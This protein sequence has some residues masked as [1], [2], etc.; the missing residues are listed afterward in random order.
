MAGFGG[1]SSSGGGM[2]KKQKKG[3]DQVLKLKPKSQWDKY[4]ILKKESRV[5]VA[6]RSVKSDGTAGEWFDVGQIKS[7]GNEFTELAVVVQRGMI[8]EHA[9]R[10]FP[11]Q[12]LPKDQVEWAYADSD[13]DGDNYTWVAVD[14][15]VTSGA[16]AG[17]EK[18]IGFEGNPD[19][20]GYYSRVVKQ[21]AGDTASVTLA[22]GSNAPDRSV[23]PRVK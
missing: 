20:T 10:L 11:L 17:I 5:K 14:K 4:K 23:L 19:A 7:E 6:A 8:V 12:F 2:K 21:F 16:P 15:S 22:A 18:K 1:S 9:K 3:T 13:G